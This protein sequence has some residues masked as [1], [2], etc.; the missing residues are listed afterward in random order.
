[1]IQLEDSSLEEEID[2][3]SLT[4]HCHGWHEYKLKKDILVFD[5]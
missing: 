5:G 3:E 1:M 4:D 2:V